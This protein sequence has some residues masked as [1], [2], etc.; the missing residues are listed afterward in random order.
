VYDFFC[1]FSQSWLNQSGPSSKWCIRRLSRA[2]SCKEAPNSVANT[3]LVLQRTSLLAL[4][5][6]EWH[7]KQVQRKS[8]KPICNPTN[9]T[10]AP[11]FVLLEAMRVPPSD[12]ARCALYV[13]LLDIVHVVA[14]RDKQIEE[15]FA[16]HF[17]LHLHS[18]T[19][20]ER[21]SASNNERKVMSA[22]A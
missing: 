1:E 13:E 9:P 6:V 8:P 3:T 12:S 15:Q 7:A 2:N 18:A 4:G 22:K 20:F 16:T 11:S 17:H 19:T 10:T 21:L 5:R 14:H